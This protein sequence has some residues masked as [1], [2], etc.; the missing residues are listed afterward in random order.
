MDD[1]DLA[2]DFK[3]I[4]NIRGDFYSPFYPTN[5]PFVPG[6]AYMMYVSPDIQA[7]VISF[8]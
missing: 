4:K 8:E 2:N 1:Y 5:I 7:P 6:E 3:V